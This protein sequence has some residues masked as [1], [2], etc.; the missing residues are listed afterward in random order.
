MGT[1][2]LS[3]SIH[4]ILAREYAEDQT[5]NKRSSIDNQPSNMPS[6]MLR[7]LIP[8]IALLA[9]VQAADFPSPVNVQFISDLVDDHPVYLW[10]DMTEYRNNY[11]EGILHPPMT[12]AKPEVVGNLNF[13]HADDWMDRRTIFISKEGH[14]PQTVG[15]FKSRVSSLTIIS[16]LHGSVETQDPPSY[17]FNST[18]K[19][20]TGENSMVT[21]TSLTK[22]LS[23]SSAVI[24]NPKIR[25]RF[26]PIQWRNKSKDPS[27]SPSL[28]TQTT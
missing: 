16:V 15:F 2:L 14:E 26:L 6:T 21:T 23:I 27:S 12:D 3:L 4:H 20:K 22:K 5:I 1:S 13:T 10:D 7:Y 19:T 28:P 17:P 24:W 9:N 25:K 18:R 11:T 8:T